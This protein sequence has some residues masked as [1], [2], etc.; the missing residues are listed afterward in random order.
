MT[1]SLGFNKAESAN[2]TFDCVRYSMPKEGISDFSSC[3][4]CADCSVLHVLYR[5]VPLE[6]KKLEREEKEHTVT[7]NV[8]TLIL[9][10]QSEEIPANMSLRNSEK[11]RALKQ[12][13]DK[14]G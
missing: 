8:Q 13:T 11:T 2:F 9:N 6:E 14:C 12:F 1:P 5:E 7:H 4:R 3:T 10:K